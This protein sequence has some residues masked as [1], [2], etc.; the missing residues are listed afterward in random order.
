M[1]IL[2]QCP[3]CRQRQAL[4]N[5]ACRC[6]EKLD[7][8]KRSKR[9]RYWISYRLPGG[10]QRFEVVGFSIDE[11]RDAEGKRRGQ[12]REGRIFDMLPDTK[13]TFSELSAWFMELDRIK[14]LAFFKGIRRHVD[15]LNETFGNRQISKLTREE[16]QG[17]Q[18]NL[19][20]RYSPSYIDQITDTAKWMI[21]EALDSEIVGG[22]LLK[23]FRKL[24]GLLRKGANARKR[25][26]THDEYRRLF[27]ALLPHLKPVV[28]MGYWTGMRQGEILK[29][30]WDKVDLQKRLIHLGA[31]DTKERRPKTVPIARPLRDILLTLP[32]RASAGQVMTYAGRGMADI[33]QGIEAA[34]RASGIAYGRHTPQGFIFHDLRHTFT[35]NARRAGLHPN[36]VRAIMGHTGGNDMNQ[37][38]DTVVGS[39]LVAAVD[40]LEVFSAG[41][42][43]NVDQMVVTS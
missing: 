42:D 6:G 34:C 3:R 7:Q 11:A 13:K 31:S 14:R 22:D 33:T 32:G 16:L 1:A 8:A 27:D 18:A 37:R 9:V 28:A 21:T 41:V 5:K 26:L 43:Q 2:Q 20:Q 35:T 39:D 23:P 10:K 12:K 4:K 29:L 36:V 24:K 15:L 19:R 25:V 17:F 40:R 38:Y 30:T